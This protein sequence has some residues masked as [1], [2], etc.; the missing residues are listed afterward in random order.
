MKTKTRELKL[1]S[2][3]SHATYTTRYFDSTEEEEIADFNFQARKPAPAPPRLMP[4][5]NESKANQMLLNAVRNRQ[6]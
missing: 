5:T 1:R 4:N 2:E 3:L 6:R